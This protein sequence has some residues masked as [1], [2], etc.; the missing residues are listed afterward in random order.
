MASRAASGLVGSVGSALDRLGIDGDGAEPKSDVEVARAVFGDSASRR[1]IAAADGVLVAYCLLSLAVIIRAYIQGNANG[2]GVIAIAVLLVGNVAISAQP[3]RWRRPLRVE[4]VRAALG[5][6]IAPVA[7]LTTTEPFGHWWP[8]F[9]LMCV[10]SA[11]TVGVLTASP[12]SGR[13]I[14]TYYVALFAVSALIAGDV[15]LARGL[16]V[17]GGIAIAGLVLGECVAGL[18]QKLAVERAQHAQIEQLMLRVFPESVAAALEQDLSV[19]DEFDDASILFADIQG[20][21]ELASRLT[22]AEVVILLNEVFSVFDDLVDEMGL[23]KIKTIGDCYM[24]AAGVPDPRPDHATALCAFG[25]RL[26][27]LMGEREFAGRRLQFRVGI[28]SGPVIAGIVGQKRFL[29]DL[30]G[31]AVNLASRMES[32]GTAGVVQVTAA[33]YERIDHDFVCEPQGVTDIKGKGPMPVWH[34]VGRRPVSGQAP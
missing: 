5:C 18:G 4:L 15:T 2:G 1:V 3:I 14:V 31:D 17:G 29:Y 6:V 21:T 23:E 16:V 11:V 26:Q 25:L 7:Y 19:A 30:W 32:H 27:E 28:N 12:R 24:V 10:T 13:L 33:T 22:P 34:V 9:L 8:G 20:F